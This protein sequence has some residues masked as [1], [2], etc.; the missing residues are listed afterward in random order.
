MGMVP[1]CKVSL[2]ESHGSHLPTTSMGSV[3]EIHLCKDKMLSFL[4]FLSTTSMGSVSEIHL[5]KDKILSFL[6][7]LSTTS[8]GPL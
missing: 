4:N 7:F 8:M 6:N 2:L 5:Y 3:S 1:I